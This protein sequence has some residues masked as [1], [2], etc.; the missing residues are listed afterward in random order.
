VVFFGIM[1]VARRS[2][3]RDYLRPVGYG[4]LVAGG[5]TLVVC[6]YPLWFQFFGPQKYHGLPF[7][8][9]VYSTDPATYFAFSR[10]SLAGAG[11]VVPR[12][13][14]SATE[15]NG[16]FGFPLMI[17]VAVLAGW[18]WRRYLVIRAATATAVIFALL[19][20][21]SRITLHG[22]KTGIPGPYALIAWLPVVDLVTPTRLTLMMIPMIGIIL[23]IGINEAIRL[24]PG[25]A[26]AGGSRARWVTIWT[27][28]VVGALLPAAPTPLTAKDR[29]PVPA[30]IA[31]GTWRRYV[32]DGRTIV[33]VPLSA[34][35]QPDGIWWSA[36][37]LQD[38]PIPRGYFLGPTSPADRQAIFGAPPR[39][40][41]DLLRHVSDTGTVPVVNDQDRAAARTDLAYWRAAI[42]VLQPGPSEEAL[43][44]TTSELLGAQPRWV[45]GVWIWKVS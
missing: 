9:S 27:V 14:L 34:S 30:F 20:M 45:D 23:A 39:P 31:D 10:E 21:G 37:Q 24:A 15:E 7:D 11:G 13:V 43:W 2:R 35:Y 32:P 42:V 17:F 36:D 41:S 22:V 3:V 5:V 18:L 33:P 44:K 19:A 6:A 29:G 28:A 8:P 25:G 16:F 40:T 4:L 1:A 26:N 12:F 38:F